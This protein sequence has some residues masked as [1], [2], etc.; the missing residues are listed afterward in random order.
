[1]RSTERTSGPHTILRESVSASFS[2]RIHIHGL[3][4]V[5]LQGFGGGAPVPPLR[6]GGGC[7]TAALL[8]SYGFLYVD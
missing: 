4:K 6:Y 2:R 5:I 1:M 8:P 3:L 7:D